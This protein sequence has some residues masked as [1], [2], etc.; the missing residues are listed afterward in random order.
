MLVLNNRYIYMILKL[1]LRNQQARIS[2]RISSTDNT[3]INLWLP[4]AEYKYFEATCQSDGSNG[5]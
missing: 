2:I 4:D 1:V 3:V 5:K